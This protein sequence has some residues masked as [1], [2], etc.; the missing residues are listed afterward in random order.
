MRKV[1]SLVLL[2]S[3]FI[4]CTSDAPK[5]KSQ[6]SEPFIVVGSA[7]DPATNSLII[8]IRPDPPFTEDAAK[9]AAEI[10]GNTRVLA[11]APHR[12]G[13]LGAEPAGRQ[14]PVRRDE[15]QFDAGGLVS[16]TAGAAPGGSVTYTF[17]A[18]NPGS[19]LYQSGTEPQKQVRMG[20]FGTLVVRPTMGAAFAYNRADSQ[21]T[22]E[23][24]FLVLLSAGTSWG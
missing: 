8:S 7:V 12:P 16:L 19:F 24:E 11:R 6:P 1:L 20:L 14:Y 3:T 21:F 4:A 22:P 18:T 5:Q 23:E 13:S 10:A 9:R 2:L 17:V 15:P